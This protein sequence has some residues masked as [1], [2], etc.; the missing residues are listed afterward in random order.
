MVSVTSTL[1]AI[2]NQKALL[3]FK[4]IALSEEKYDTDILITKLGLTRKQFYCVMN[5]LIDAGLIERTRR[6][7]RI[8]YFGKIVFS[9]QEKI[10]YATNN[11]WKLNAID[12]IKYS[13][14]IDLPIEEHQALV[15]KLIDNMKSKI[16]LFRIKL[17]LI[18]AIQLSIIRHRL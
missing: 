14:K 9:A 17:V 7:Y 1:S 4:D 13:D 11:Y 3:L 8:T 12:L 16:S 18:L 5:K 6:R 15:D 10:E 2:S